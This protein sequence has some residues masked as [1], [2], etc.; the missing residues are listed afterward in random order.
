MECNDLVLRC[1]AG[2]LAVSPEKQLYIEKTVAYHF[3]KLKREFQF[4]SLIEDLMENADETHFV[5][6]MDNGRKIGFRG[7]E[8][9]KYADVVSGDEAITMIVCRTG[10]VHA[11]I[12]APCSYS[13]IPIAPTLS[14]EFGRR[15]RCF[16]PFKKEGVN[17]Q[18]RI[19]GM[20]LGTTRNCK[21]CIWT[22]SLSVH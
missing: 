22:E 17:G 14:E 5:F 7:D 3:G 21:R 19:S 4:G 10:D 2:S 15:A 8:D 16:V 6:N 18:S 11:C 20:A 1:Q 9:V 13:R 12:A